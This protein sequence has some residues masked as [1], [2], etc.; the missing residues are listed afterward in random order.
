M[1]FRMV[2]LRVVLADYN[3]EII[4]ENSNV[5]DTDIFQ[6]KNSPDKVFVKLGRTGELFFFK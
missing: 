3:E 5:T 6:S 4:N 2:E 1:V